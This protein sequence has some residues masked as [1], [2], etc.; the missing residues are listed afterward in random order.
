MEVECTGAKY[1]ILTSQE[2]KGSRKKYIHICQFLI[3]L[4]T[5]RNTY[6]TLLKIVYSVNHR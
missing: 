4:K 2:E 5:D 6:T 3:T 1:Y